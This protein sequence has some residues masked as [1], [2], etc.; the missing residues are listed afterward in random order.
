VVPP[1]FVAPLTALVLTTSSQQKNDLMLA[2]TGEPG[3]PYD[4]KTQPRSNVPCGTLN[5]NKVL[6]YLL[7]RHP[8]G[9][10]QPNKASGVDFTIRTCCLTT[11]GSFLEGVCGYSSPCRFLRIYCFRIIPKAVNVSRIPRRVGHRPTR[12]GRALF[13]PGSS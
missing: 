8:C 4:D 2:L 6:C 11:T 5:Q 10:N 9:G 3:L 13:S 1:A 7:F 12:R